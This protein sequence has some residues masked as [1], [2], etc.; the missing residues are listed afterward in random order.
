MKADLHAVGGGF[1]VTYKTVSE[2][3]NE[4]KHKTTLRDLPHVDFE[5]IDPIR[6]FKGYKNQKHFP[7]WWWCTSTGRLVECESWLERDTAMV[8][9]YLGNATGLLGQPFTLS[10]AEPNRRSGFASH[11]P[12]FQVVYDDG[13][14][15][16]VDCKTSSAMN[17]EETL[18]KFEMTQEACDLVGWS[19][20]V[21]H[22]VDPILLL[23][24]QWL[25]G[26][27]R[28]L[29]PTLEA[30][31]PRVI[32]VCAEPVMIVDVEQAAGS[33]TER[34]LWRPVLFH[35][36]WHH[37]IETIVPLQQRNLSEQTVVRLAPDELDALGVA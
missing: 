21:V 16:I 18:H 6:K 11:T 8:I 27:R 2:S 19:Y 22:E 3:G 14:V 17:K 34:V 37:V 5:S 35:L 36:M 12:D 31:V 10:W 25:S 24:L 20:E 4:K 29:H 1:R 7:N 26:Y 9:D 32:D 28:P 13:S 30:L 15:K 23:N 33:N